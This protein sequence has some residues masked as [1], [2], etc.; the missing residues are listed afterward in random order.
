MTVVVIQSVDLSGM[1]VVTVET[2]TGLW[3][4]SVW[5]VVSTATV[6]SGRVVP[7]DVVVVTGVGLSVVWT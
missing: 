4:V 5:A 2:A 6:V 7:F 1:E 3:V